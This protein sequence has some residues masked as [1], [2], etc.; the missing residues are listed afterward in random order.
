MYVCARVCWCMCEC[1]CLALFTYVSQKVQRES[2][3]RSWFTCPRWTWLS[4]LYVSL[5]PSLHP[6]ALTEICG[7]ENTQRK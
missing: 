4:C 5:M 3:R 2:V 6:E 7:V 1:V